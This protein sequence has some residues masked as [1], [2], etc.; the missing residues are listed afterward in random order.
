MLKDYLLVKYKNNENLYIPVEKIDLITKFQ[1]GDGI[2]PKINTLGG[3]EWQKTKLRVRSKIKNIA[4]KLIKISAERKLRDGFAF[5]KDTEDQLE[6]EKEFIYEETKDQLVSTKQIK[7]D[8]ESSSP[9][10]RLLCGD[11]GYGKTEVAF[12]AI[13]K[14][15][16]NNKQVAYLCPTTLLS[17]QQYN[18]ALDR[19][20]IIR[21]QLHY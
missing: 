11:V 5:L 4:E 7:D 9:M 12:R 16:S 20:K 2:K 19:F 13:F 8:M 15:I 1:E 17:K 6:F 10:D 21:F 18:N 14:A 3:T